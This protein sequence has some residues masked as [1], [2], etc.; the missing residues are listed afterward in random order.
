MNYLKDK[1]IVLGICGGIAAYK[2]CELVRNLVKEEAS[3]QVVMTK[4]ATRFITPLTLHTLS[5]RKVA[6][7]QYD[8]EMGSGIS[9]IEIAD[10]ADLVIITPATASFIGRIASGIADNLLSTVIMATQAPVMFC[11]SMNVNML[12]NPAV[13][14]NIQ[15]LLKYGYKIIQPGEGYL[16]CGWEG[17]GRMPD[18]PVIVSEMERMLAPKDLSGKKILITTGPT[19]EY[20]DPARYISNPS[21]GKMGFS[22]AKAAW[23]RGA[24]VTTI[25]G[26]TTVEPPNGIRNIKVT[27]AKDMYEEVMK[28]ADNYHIIIKTAAVSDY[29]PVKTNKSKIKKDQDNMSL[30]MKRT[31]DILS[32]L[33]KNYT[34]KIIVGFAAET[35]DIVSHS[36]KKIREKNLDLIVANDISN[37]QA[38]FGSDLNKVSIIDRKSNVTEIPLMS[39]DDVAHRILDSIINLAKGS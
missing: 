12:D 25:S 23:L 34:G 2:N 15:K 13:Q 9:H 36:I 38:G 20:I 31:T 11:P 8:L 14:E 1:N 39:K 24:S 16:A 3:V 28:Q 32:E 4:N 26:Q 17:K 7:D 27:S 10:N 5:G 21:T 22:L 29:T 35:N 6:V 19:R 18:I 30:E 33:G 37:K